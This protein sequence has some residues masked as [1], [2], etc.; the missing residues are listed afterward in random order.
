MRHL[1]I[2]KS[3]KFVPDVIKTINDNFYCGHT[4]LVFDGTNVNSE[5]NVR[6]LSSKSFSD[7][8]LSLR[9]MVKAEKVYFHGLFVHTLVVSCSL[10]KKILKKSTWIL[11]GN[12]LYAYRE[13]N[14]SLLKSIYEFFRAGFIKNV[15]T[16]AVSMDGEFRLAKAWYNTNA[17]HFKGF[18][19]PSV[20]VSEYISEAPQNPRDEDI[21]K[22]ILVG[23][24]ATRSNNHIDVFNYINNNF[25][26]DYEVI[27]PLSYGCN[28]YADKVEREGEKILGDK[29]FSLRKMMPMDEYIKML[30]SVDIAIFDMERQQAM[31]NI[32]QLLAMGKVVCIR[33]STSTYEHLCEMGVEVFTKEQI[34]RCD[35]IPDCTG[36]IEIVRNGYSKEQLVIN[37]SELFSNE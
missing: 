12:D 7:I 32:I 11:W 5:K 14:D 13:R 29:F 28:D 37:L 4:F 31:G 9:Y 15:G 20:T 3:E 2:M 26:F 27:C 22:K 8:I 17:T 23:N 21:V 24:S 36:N 34:S 33:S 18:T 1:H 6:V 10:F 35:S 19:Y 30:D 25:L 16:I